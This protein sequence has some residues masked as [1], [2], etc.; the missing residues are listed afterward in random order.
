MRKQ[1]VIALAT[2]MSLSATAHA[3]PSSSQSSAFGG[4]GYGGSATGLGGTASAIG[5]EGGAGG[6]GGYGGLGGIGG[7]GGMGGNGAGGTGGQGTGGQIDIDTPR[8]SPAVFLNVP[9]P[10]AACQA[11]IGGFLSFI[12]GIGLAGSRTLEECE[13]RETARLSYAIEQKEIALEILCMTT[14]ASKTRHCKKLAEAN[15]N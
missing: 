1:A 12:G 7:A 6:L 15:K 10:T 3:D 4:S 14:H 9:A 2:I 8:Q 13:M 11:T 5:G